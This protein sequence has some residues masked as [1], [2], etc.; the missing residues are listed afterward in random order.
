MKKLFLLM[1][2]PLIVTPV[3]SQTEHGKLMPVTTGSKSAL[4]Y[5]NQA[6]KNLDDVKV[7][8]ALETFIEALN[9]DPDFFM[10][11]YQLAFYYILNRDVDNFDKYAVAAINCKAKLSDTEELLKE[12]MVRLQQG[13]TNVIDL[14]KKLVDLYPKDPNSYNNLVYFQSLAGDSAGVVETLNKAIKIATNPATFYNQLGYAYLTLNQSDKAEEAFDKYIELEPKNPNVY[15]SKGDFYMYIKKYDKAYESYMM[16]YSM[17]PSF[18]HDKAELAKQLYER[19][20]GKK[21]E[22]ITI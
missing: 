1:I 14:G 20:E 5:Y 9:Q 21:L 12:A 8:E 13:R 17:N 16:A 4:S 3:F 19:T 10:A 7:K 15:D 18:S 2:L 22:I 11:N 6:M